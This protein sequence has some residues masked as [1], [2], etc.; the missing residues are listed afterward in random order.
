MQ[1][2]HRA[3]G[4]RIAGCKVQGE[5]DAELDCAGCSMYHIESSKQF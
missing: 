1:G 4:A 2:M 3:T 5:R